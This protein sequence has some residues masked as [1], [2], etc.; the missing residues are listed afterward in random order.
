[1]VEVEDLL[2]DVGRKELVAFSIGPDDEE[3]GVKLGTRAEQV[4][5]GLGDMILNDQPRF[6]FL[7]ENRF[8]LFSPSPHLASS[9]LEG[10]FPINESLRPG[11]VINPRGRP[12]DIYGDGWEGRNS[13]QEKGKEKGKG[14]DELGKL[15]YPN[16]K[17]IERTTKVH[18]FKVVWV[19]ENQEEKLERIK[20]CFKG[21][22]KE[23][24]FAL[25]LSDFACLWG[26]GGFVSQNFDSLV[27]LGTGFRI[28]LGL[29]KER[30]D[31]RKH[32]RYIAE[33]LYGDTLHCSFTP[34]LT[35]SSVL[36]N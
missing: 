35:Q 9:E 10:L 11:G 22:G 26:G 13:G 14:S 28:G 4:Q 36:L 12:F 33:M 20:I 34:S 15:S 5:K 3:S 2:Q 16:T 24:C 32:G 1:V 19:T 23:F 8:A 25:V 31:E 30:S 18:A 7:G 29:G 27:R 17:G 21:T 6:P